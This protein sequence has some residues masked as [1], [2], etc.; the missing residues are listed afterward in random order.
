MLPGERTEA[1]HRGGSSR[2]AACRLCPVALLVAL[3]ACPS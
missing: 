1:M 2:A 3:L